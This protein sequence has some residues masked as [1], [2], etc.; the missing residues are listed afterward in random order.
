[1]LKLKKD[2]FDEALVKHKKILGALKSFKEIDYKNNEEL[3]GKL[4]AL[5]RTGRELSLAYSQFKCEK[6]KSEERLQ[7][8]HLIM[9]E[10][11]EFTDFYRYESQRK[12]WANILILC[13]KC[14]YEIHTS[15]AQFPKHKPNLSLYIQ[16]KLI[17]KVKRK[18][19]TEQ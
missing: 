4:M 16:P 15:I 13:S 5:E 7:F 10:V 6:C 19:F 14:H 2:K 17:E 11:K 1:M 18:F 9:R 12:Y 3:V 8:H